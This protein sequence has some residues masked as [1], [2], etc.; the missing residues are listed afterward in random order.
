MNNDCNMN[1]EV[2]LIYV[3]N[4]DKI[5]KFQLDKES[6]GIYDIQIACAYVKKMFEDEGAK[7]VAVLAPVL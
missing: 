4:G 2:F 3:R 5:E 6:A 1:N 7:H